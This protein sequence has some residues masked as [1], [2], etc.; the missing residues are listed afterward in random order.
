MNELATALVTGQPI[1]ITLRKPTQGKSDEPPLYRFNSLHSIEVDWIPHYKIER[2]REQ[3]NDFKQYTSVKFLAIRMTQC[4]GRFIDDERDMLLE[5]K[6]S[7][8]DDA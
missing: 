6:L 2:T 7:I 5:S 1:R 4:S 3:Y 8:Q